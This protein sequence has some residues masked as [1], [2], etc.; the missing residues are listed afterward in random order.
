MGMRYRLDGTD[1]D[2][3]CASVCAVPTTNSVDEEVVFAANCKAFPSRSGQCQYDETTSRMPLGL[4]SDSLKIVVITCLNY[5]L[6]DCLPLDYQGIWRLQY[7]KHQ[8]AY[9]LVECCL[10]IYRVACDH[11]TSDVAG[12]YLLFKL[13]TSLGISHSH[14]QATESKVEM[15][16]KIESAIARM[17]WR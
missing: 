7:C 4:I 2:D 17:K 11:A 3:V 9:L 12:R 15:A 1:M 10:Y 8:A 5:I 13:F 14:N 6:T 16:T